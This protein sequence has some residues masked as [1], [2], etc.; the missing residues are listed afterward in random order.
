M[1]SELKRHEQKISYARASLWAPFW[2]VGMVARVQG[3]V[4]AVLLEA[5]LRKLKVLHPPLASRVRMQQDGTAW[6]TTE[7][8]GD[9]PLEVRPRASGSDWARVFLEQ[10]RVPFAFGRGPVTRFLLLLG[11]DS[12][13]LVAIAP[14]V[15][16]DG[17]SMTHVMGDLVAL[18]NDPGRDV[19]RPAD[20][21]AVTRQ[22]VPE[23]ASDNLLLRGIVQVLNRAWPARRAVLHQDEYEDLHRQYWT[24]QQHDLLAF[25]LSP[26]ETSVL[27]TRCKEHG[28]GVTAALAAAF[29]LAQGNGQA[30]RRPARH[31]IS[32]PV[33]IRDRLTPSPGQAVGVYASCID[34]TLPSSLTVTFWELARQGH[35]R[36]YRVLRNRP[37]ILRP[38]VLEALDPSISDGLVAA[39]CTDRW[40][41]EYRLLSRL[42][43]TTA[44]TRCLTV[45][46]IGRI[47]LPELGEPHR[48][49]S[50]VPLPPIGPGSRMML[51]ALTVGGRMNLVLK[52][53]QAD[54]DPAAAAG[55]RDRALDYL[56]GK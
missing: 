27:A 6:L 34:V 11:D 22:T 35:D 49:E 47:S 48:L 8:V 5:A 45:S 21:P 16:C 2:A 15:V 7:G 12:S 14:H 20:P 10:E 3:Q 54:M 25:S 44:E 26:G 1:D 19:V 9:F 28:V 39:L 56:L 33:S 41:L 53:R 50:L 38:M 46:N 23:A 36:M 29:L 4:P 40:S 52:Y 13:D 55:V 18:L 17:Y 30:C 32:V 43:R 51:N 42:V 31:K 37:R 24:R